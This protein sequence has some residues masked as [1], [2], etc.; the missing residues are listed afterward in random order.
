M[1]IGIKLKEF[2]DLGD[3][4]ESFGNK[5][6]KVIQVNARETALEFGQDLRPSASPVFAGLTVD[7]DTLYVD[8]V[9]HRVGIGTTAPNKTLEVRKDVAG[10]MG[11]RIRNTSSDA[12]AYV[13]VEAKNDSTQ[14]WA[15][16]LYSS[17]ASGSGYLGITNKAG[18]TLVLINGGQ[19]AIGTYTSH[20]FFIS[21]KNTARIVVKSNGNIGIN[22]SDFGTDAVGVI[23]IKNGTAPTS[24]PADM[25][26]LY[27]EDVAGSSELK[28]RDEAGNVTTLSP[29]NFTLFKPKKVT[30]C[31]GLI[32]QEMII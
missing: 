10:V 8:S 17:G 20:D 3:T 29:H 13:E 15:L 26:Q 5:A 18:A 25:I 6:G 27:A 9:N 30:F 22:T 11:V 23:G 19:G 14:Y 21:T 31:L 32:I 7:T 24:S 16:H 2:L 1:A 4:P 28:V 12:A